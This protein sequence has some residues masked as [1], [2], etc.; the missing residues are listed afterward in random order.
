MAMMRRRVQFSNDDHNDIRIFV[1]PI[2][3]IL[4][5][6]AVIKKNTFQMKNRFIRFDGDH[7]YGP[8]AVSNVK[9]SL[10]HP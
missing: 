9:C 7:Y 1:V 8:W 4:I 3:T 6:G 10:L 2:M 5:V